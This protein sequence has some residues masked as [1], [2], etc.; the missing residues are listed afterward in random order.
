MSKY[1]MWCRIALWCFAALIGTACWARDLCKTPTPTVDMQTLMIDALAFPAN[2]WVCIGPLP[3]PE[4]A[5][6]QH[7]EVESLSTQLCYEGPGCQTFGAGQR[8]YRYRS[9][10]QARRAFESD[11]STSEFPDL[12]KTMLTPWHVP[13]GWAHDSRFAEQLEFACAELDMGPVGPPE[14]RCS[15]VA[16]YGQYISALNS[17]WSAECMTLDDL[18]RVLAA[19]DERMALYLGKDMD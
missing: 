18:G 13:E 3:P 7:G 10:V 8:L 15:A 2:W 9:E 1:R 4:R 19:I 14:W 11:F 16:Q 6:G 5:R 17:N 12:G